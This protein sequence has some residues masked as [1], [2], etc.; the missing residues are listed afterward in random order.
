MRNYLSTHE[1]SLPVTIL[2]VTIFSRHDAHPERRGRS[3]VSAYCRHSCRRSA[4]N[5]GAILMV[6]DDAV[7]RPRLMGTICLTS[8]QRSHPNGSTVSRSMKQKARLD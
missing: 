4:L 7:L 2:G 1:K 6:D 3:P 8:Q 5:R